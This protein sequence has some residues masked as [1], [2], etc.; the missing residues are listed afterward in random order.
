M[1]A[2]LVSPGALTREID[3]SLYVPNLAST[4]LAMVGTCTKGPVNQITL[5]TSTNELAQTFGDPNPNHPMILAAQLFFAA[6]QQLKV[7]RVGH[8][9]D[10][11]TASIAVP[12]AG[13][14]SALVLG[15]ASGP[16]TFSGPSA[17]QLTSIQPGPFNIATG[18]NDTL[19]IAVDGGSNTVVTLTAGT[20]IT[21]ATI[22][23]EIAAAVTTIT[24]S[25][26]ATG[27]QLTS[28]TTGTSSEI[29]ITAGDANATLG[30]VVGSVN[31]TAGNNSL[32]ISVDAGSNQ[33]ITFTPGSLT[34]A[35][36]VQAINAVLAGATASQYNNGNQVQITSTSTGSAA[37]LQVQSSGTSNTELGFDTTLHSGSNSTTAFTVNAT[38][39]GT[40][41][42]NLQVQFIAGSI[43][44]TVT[45]QVLNGGV[46]VETFRNLTKEPTSSSTSY[47]SQINDISANIT[48]SDNTATDQQPTLGIYTLVGGSDGLNGITDA[49]YVGADNQNGTITGLQLF[50]D[51]GT[52]DGDINL[53]A[54]PG[55]TTM[56]VHS[57]IVS[58][59]ESRRDCFGLCDPPLG[60]GAQDVVN[61]VTGS[62]SYSSSRIALNSSYA[63]MFWPW[64]QVF[65]SINDIDEWVPPSA[66]FV[67]AAA[68][69]DETTDPWY[70][71]AGTTRG[72]IPEAVG[73]ELTLTK[74]DRDYVYES[75][76]RVNPIA[77]FTK[78]GV[79]V[80]GNAT[81]L[82]TPTALDRINVRRLMLYLE[83]AIATSVMGLVFEQDDVKTWRRFKNLVTPILNDIENREG[84]VNYRVVC[85]ST[86]NTPSVVDNNEMVANIFIKPTKTAEFIIVNFVLVPQ[87]STFT[88]TVP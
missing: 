9:S 50:A 60:L 54:V 8:A 2:F 53:I 35:Q 85:D 4:I 41:G 24:A 5:V 26:N 61:F 18:V 42:N 48:I 19:N 46:V 77:N 6:G 36:I 22:A 43:S 47:V 88:E 57:A 38:T 67:R 69:T 58:L 23:A 59:C 12:A 78:Y 80:W 15:T 3:L 1:S 72:V 74:G 81:L 28:K 84:I 49:D 45:L 73:I 39:P 52:P 27:I 17:A 13:A 51:P 75:Q 10:L 70:A 7:V 65:D 31:G 55:I 34:A 68:I 83:K 63:G 30:F 29:N 76:P 32:V 79:T 71:A 33:T 37:S 14:G 40:W 64:I 62:G 87:G 44:G 56:N 82:G 11:L 20:A 25:S 66:A 16:F 86:T 21:A